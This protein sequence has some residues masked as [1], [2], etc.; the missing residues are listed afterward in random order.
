MRFHLFSSL[1]DLIDS[2]LIVAGW[3]QIITDYYREISRERGIEVGIAADH[4]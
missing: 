2:I 4:I 1:V 3:T